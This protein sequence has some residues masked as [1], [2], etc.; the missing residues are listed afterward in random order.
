M[1]SSGGGGAPGHAGL[2]SGLPSDDGRLGPGA[3][4]PHDGGTDGGHEVRLCNNI[5]GDLNIVYQ[6]E[7][8]Y[9]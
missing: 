1:A 5:D 7:R 3:W 8:K 9:A 2:W 4:S 6:H